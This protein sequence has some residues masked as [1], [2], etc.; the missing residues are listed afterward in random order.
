PHCLDADGA[1]VTTTSRHSTVTTT[2]GSHHYQS[3]VTTTIRKSPLNSRRLS[4]MSPLH[5]SS[6]A[7]GNPISPTTHRSAIALASKQRVFTRQSSLSLI[8]ARLSTLRLCRLLQS[9]TAPRLHLQAPGSSSL[10]RSSSTPPFDSNLKS[11]T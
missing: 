7:V 5:R 9:S 4:A 3:A 1:S 10:F 8:S 2:G 6:I 11:S